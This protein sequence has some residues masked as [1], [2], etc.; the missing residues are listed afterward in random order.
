[1]RVPITTSP[2][3][4]KTNACSINDGTVSERIENGLVVI[5]IFGLSN[6]DKVLVQQ[7]YRHI[8]I[9]LKIHK[10]LLFSYIMLF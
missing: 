4:I 10:Y 3:I 2:T 5:I 8:F 6:T 1:M 9:L 7:C